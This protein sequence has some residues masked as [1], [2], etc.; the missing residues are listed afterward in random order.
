MEAER[1][2]TTEFGQ[3]ARCPGDKWAFTYYLPNPV[4]RQITFDSE[5]VLLLSDADNALGHLQGLGRLIPEPDLLVGP[6]LTREALASSRIEGTKASLTDVLRAEEVDVDKSDDIAE[7]ERYLSAIKRG[8]KLIE[9]LPI[10]QRLLKEVHVALM[11]GVRGEERQPGEIR[12][13]PVWIGSTTPS[14]ALFVPPLPEHLAELI[15]DWERFMNEPSRLPLLVRSA[16]MHYQ[17]ETIHPFLD[18]NGRMGR[19]LIVLQLVAEGRLSAPLLYLS[20]YLE[21]YRQ[22]YYERL[23]AVRE[24]GDLQGWIQFFCLA[25]KAQSDDAVERAG[26]LVELREGYYKEASTDRSRV[27]SVIPLVFKNPFI[28]ARRVQASIGVTAQGAR[29]LLERAVAY[30]WLEHMGTLGSSG[31]HYYA[32][33]KVL[34]VLESP[35]TYESPLGLRRPGR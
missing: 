22:E 33:S 13:S 20:G 7:V 21:T 12:W 35:T 1:Y 15:A 27:S 25:V 34:E 23:Q 30:G 32:A 2:K 3:A 24:V 9:T 5:T 31:R 6:F 10:S 11:T 16:L 4:P 8:L 29:N 14:T 28:T 26:R 19:L 17:F 18:G